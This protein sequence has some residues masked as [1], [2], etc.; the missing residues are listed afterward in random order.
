MFGMAR[1]S[2][3]KPFTALLISFLMLLTIF[4]IYAWGNV[5]DLISDVLVVYALVGQAVILY[6]LLQGVKAAYQAEVLEE[7]YKL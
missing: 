5:N 1:W 6:F 7:E 3:Q 4:V 2:I